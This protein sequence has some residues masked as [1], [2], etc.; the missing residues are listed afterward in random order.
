MEIPKDSHLKNNGMDLEKTCSHGTYGLT[1]EERLAQ[2]GHPQELR[3]TF[4]LPAL[5]A[6]CLCLMAT[7]EALSAVIAAALV[8]GGAPCLFYNYV[9]SFLSSVCIASSLGEIASIYPTAGGQYHWVAALCPPST[10]SVAAWVTGWVSIGG[11]IVFTAS[12]AFAA[13]L[14]IQSLIIVN[15][16]NYVPTRWQALLFYW[17]I[18]AFAGALNI[19]GTKLIP[20]V[21]LV[22]GII[23]I[24]AFVGIIVTLGVLASKN[25]S[26]FVFTEV[27]N[28]SGWDSDAVSWLVGLQSAVYPFLG[29]D[30]ACHLSEEL[31]HASLNVPRAM[32]GSVVLNGLMGFAYCIVLLYSAGSLESLLGTPTGFPYM[33]IY[34]DATHSRAGTTVMALTLVIIAITATIAGVTS[35]SR[36]LWAFARDKATPFGSYLSFVNAATQIPINAVVLVMA[37]QALLGLIYLGNSTAFNAILSIAIIGLYLSYGLPIVYMLVYGRFKKL[38]NPDFGP[39]RLHPLLGI[40]ANVISIVW[41]TVA[42]IFSTFPTKIPATPENMNYSTV[43]LAGWMAFGMTYYFW[44]GRHKFQVPITETSTLLGL[45]VSVS[46]D[47]EK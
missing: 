35:T 29:Y 40:L 41:I 21:N 27:V 16:D 10:R 22:S 32:I 7:W 17:A 44:A 25:T 8:S 33:Q 24:A 38:T 30:A 11:Q 31:P 12:A 46:V 9:L 26:S 36:T 39:F 43:V 45:P 1:D 34:L 42:V 14:Q 47:E 4:S 2:I 5:G 18:L 23:H 20:Q 19:W 28:T 15:D 13:G 6:L 37:L 3:R